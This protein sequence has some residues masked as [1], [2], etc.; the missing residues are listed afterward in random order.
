MEDE[1][2][3]YKGGAIPGEPKTPELIAKVCDDLKELLLAKNRKY[4]DSALNPKRIFSRASAEEQLNV[5][6]DDKISRIM[7]G[8]SDEDEDPELDLLGYLILKRVQ[9][10]SA[11]W[12]TD[13]IFAQ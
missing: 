11:K 12:D 3:R 6:I 8:Q 1:D 4:G 7:S 13:D 10:Y 2:F 5:R 9:R